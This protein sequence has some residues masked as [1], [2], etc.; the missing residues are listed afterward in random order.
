MYLVNCQQI[1]KA[2]FWLVRKD[3]IVDSPCEISCQK[4]V[5]KCAR[6]PSTRFN[7]YS[8]NTYDSILV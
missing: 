3:S 8:F 1:H 6:V 2:G 5:G 7:F 4:L